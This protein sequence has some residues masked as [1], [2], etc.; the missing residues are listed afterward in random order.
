MATLDLGRLKIGIVVDNNKA[1]KAL[2]NTRNISKSTGEGIITDWNKVTSTLNT[3]GSNMT[4]YITV[5]IAAIGTAC[6][7]LASDFDET[8]NKINAVFG[9]NATQVQTWAKSAVDSMGLAQQTALDMASVFG[10]MGTG[11]G[12]TTGEAAK[13]S[14]ELVQLAADMASFK[15]ISVE[16]AQTALQGIY[17]GETEALKGLG[18]VMTEANLEQFAMNQGIKTTYK[19]MSQTEKIALRYKYV[20][21][22]TANAQGDFAKTSDGL[23]NQSRMVKENLKE[24]GV[25]FGQVLLPIVNKVITGI[26][27]LLKSFM[28]LDENQRNTIVTIGLVVAAVGPALLMVSKV[29]TAINNIKTAITNMNASITASSGVIGVVILAITTLITLFVSWKQH[30]EEVAK[31]ANERLNKS[32]DESEAR[33]R[34]NIEAEKGLGEETESLTEKLT[35]MGETDPE[36]NIKSNAPD[37]KPII[38]DLRTAIGNMLTDTGN[39]K[40]NIDDVNTS[41]GDYVT[42]LTEARKAT[43]IEHIMSLADA[44]HQG[45]ITQEEFNRYVN[46][47]VSSYKQ[48]EAGVQGTTDAFD[49][50]IKKFNGD[51]KLTLE[52]TNALL[53]GTSGLAAQGV[54]MGDQLTSAADGMAKLT[55][56]TNEGTIANGGWNITAQETAGLLSNEMMTAVN[57]ITTAYDQYEAEVDAAYKVETQQREEAADN[58]AALQSKQDALDLYTTHIYDGRSAVEALNQVEMVYGT[59]TVETL[60]ASLNERYETTNITYS[61]CIELAEDWA[62][63]EKAIQESLNEESGALAQRR[64]DSIVNAEKNLQD[65]MNTITTGWTNEQIN[66]FAKMAEQSGL[67]LDDGFIEMLKSC[68]TF[69][70][71]SQNSFNQA[72]EFSVEGF[73]TGL[74]KILPYLDGMKIDVNGKGK[75]IGTDLSSGIAKGIKNGE[76][77]A[78]NAA[79]DAVKKAIAAAKKEGDIRSPSRKMAKQ[80]G[81]PLAEGVGVGFE[82]EMPKVL[83]KVQGGIGK[84]TVGVSN[85]GSQAAANAQKQSNKSLV[86]A[87]KSM[88][89]TNKANVTQNNTFTSKELT[90]Y[91]Q[92]VQVKRLSRD[93]AG[94]FA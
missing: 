6:V 63:D 20:M 72:G 50:F 46:E 24:L 77:K 9:E 93:L 65:K 61:Q 22:A 45:S 10:D 34:K 73:K 66:E 11:M 74:N 23:A 41:L 85:G 67:K 3:V 15:N 39:L 29:I 36:I 60:K 25:Q 43:T 32:L 21:N 56:A 5:P 58:I 16:R 69:V 1:N 17:T 13:M 94:V 76:Y 87:I 2:Q 70:E 82:D 89:N 52:E 68:N 49:G 86:N 79:K 28:G 75:S 30:A 90:P 53:T 33:I 92:Q 55:Q 37:V 48:F 59:E 7:K 44:Y 88:A 80:I 57:S 27:G 4:K 54:T 19:E 91:E 8:Q 31:A 40:D 71:D 64:K 83:K 26:N 78:I 84:L 38:E 18:V 81:K 12:M 14:M 62:A 51:G 35:K 42:A 47:S